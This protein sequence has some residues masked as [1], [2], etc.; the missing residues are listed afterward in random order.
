M[1]D[2]LVLTGVKQVT[3]HTGDEMVRL[4]YPRG[5]NS[6]HLKRWWVQG[7]GTVYVDCT[8]FKVEAGGASGYL[9][10]ASSAS[11][12]LRID[13]DGSFNFQFFYI[14]EVERAALYDENWELVEHYVFPHISGGKVMTVTPANGATKPGAGGSGTT[15]G[16]ITITGSTTTTDGATEVY[17]ASSDGTAGDVVFTFTSSNGLDTVSGNS[18]TFNGPGVRTLTATGTSATATD[19]P[20]SA[21]VNVTVS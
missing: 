6:W 9:A 14:N 1:A 20:A 12:N 18:V 4:D 13:H 19:S 3:K 2:S 8:V 16:S 21:N 15:I 10:I 17:A 11:T 7:N 5:G